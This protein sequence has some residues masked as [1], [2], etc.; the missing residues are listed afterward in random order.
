MVKPELTRAVRSIRNDDKKALDVIFNE[1]HRKL[2]GFAI[3][4]LKDADEAYDL[5]Q[6]VF[7][8]LWENRGKIDDAQYFDAFLFTI[9][10]NKIISIFRKKASDSKYRDYLYA[11]TLTYDYEVE[12]A[13]EFNELNESYREIVN[14]L[15]PKRKEIFLMSRDKGLSHKEISEIKCISE[16]TVEDHITKALA[17][18]K[19]NLASKGLSAS[20]FYCLFIL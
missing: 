6:E 9:A 5:V 2:F 16:K 8:S 13:I 17:F 15:P 12:K 19:E 14:Q 7:I 10:R 4:Y 18:I 1:Y 20:L 11:N 3:S